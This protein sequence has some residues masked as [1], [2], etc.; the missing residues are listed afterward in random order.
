MTSPEAEKSRT[1]ALAVGCNERAAHFCVGT[2]GG[3]CATLNLLQPALRK[4][5]QV[6]GC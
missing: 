1:V 5:G 2:G 6:M 4:D 3:Y